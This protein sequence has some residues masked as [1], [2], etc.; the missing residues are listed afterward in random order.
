MNLYDKENES[1]FCYINVE[2]LAITDLLHQAIEYISEEYEDSKIIHCDEERLVIKL[3]IKDFGEVKD[4]C[5]FLTST[6]LEI[7]IHEF[8]IIYT[9]E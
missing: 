5:S 4:F 7:G 8:S 3:F 1:E 2:D 6:L 9:H